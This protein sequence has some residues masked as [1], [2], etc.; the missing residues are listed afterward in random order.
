M[1]EPD[2]ASTP[3]DTPP[4]WGGFSPA[5]RARDLTGAS[6]GD[7]Q[8]D[9]L[10]GRGGM[11]EVYLARQVSL[12]RPVAL[13][14]LRPDLLDNKTYLSRFE[15]EA[16]SAA[17][18]NHPNIVHIYTLGEAE[19]LRFIAM[20]YVQGTNLREYIERKGPPD[21]PQ[22][23]S[24]MRQ[25]GAAVGAAGEVGLVHR[26]IKPENM[27]LT[28]KGQ[29]KVADFGLCRDLDDDRHHVTQSGVTMGTPLYMSPEQARGQSMDH[30]SDLYSLGVTYYHMLAGQPPFRAE[31]ALA[32]AMKH[33]ADIPIDLSVHR[34]D[35][36]PDLV[37]LVMKLM[38][39]SPGDRQQSAA[40][41]LRDLT[42]I[43]EAVQVSALTGVAIPQ[44][45]LITQPSPSLS[46]TSFF[47]SRSS[48]GLQIALS[49]PGRQAVFALAAA[50]MLGGAVAGWLARPA[51]L[52]GVDSGGKPAPPALW[53]APDWSKVETKATPAAQYRHAQTL[54]NA[55]EREAA[56]VAVSGNFPQDAEW[57]S[58]SYTQ[59]ARELFRRRDRDRLKAFADVLGTTHYGRNE[60]LTMVMQAGVA[61]L[62]G[63]A[64][65]V[66]AFF[67]N[68]AFNVVTNL[69]DPAIADFGVEIALRLKDEARR[70]DLTP[71]EKSGLSDV[72]AQLIR[73]LIE[74]KR[75]D[76][77]G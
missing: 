30:R 71:T 60:V 50:G 61:E 35:L 36:P 65:K 17:K 34:P 47:D 16:W 58:R 27:L 45:V 73:K 19:G 40:E 68:N 25:A 57:A 77:R 9:R 62:D 5:P 24:I 48:T 37:R 10:L 7:F 66:I 29:V 67:H 64:D 12:N 46:S 28:R 21:L 22:A 6:L 70:L 31:T 3:T 26:D 43:R 49:W 56:W 2:R 63:D 15:A 23:L 55:A 14:V 32:L 53:I 72:E 20:E 41:M 59:L 4:G 69:L 75:R 76:I 13:K 38:A 33:V 1:S 39:K 54:P 42:R 74:I 52:L 44:A 51:D 11:G 8:V 18:L